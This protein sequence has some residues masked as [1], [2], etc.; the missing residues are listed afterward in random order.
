MYHISNEIS[1]VFAGES[2][3]CHAIGH[4]ARETPIDSY[5]ASKRHRRLAIYFSN[6]K[7]YYV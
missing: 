7:H 1:Q 2:Y 3:M 5:N 4:P 6:N